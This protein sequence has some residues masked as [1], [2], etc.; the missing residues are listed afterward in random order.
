MSLLLLGGCEKEKPA[1]Q[2][3]AHVVV[4]VTND[5]G[6]PAVGERVKMYDEAT[7]ATFRKNNLTVPNDMKITDAKG[8][9]SFDFRSDVWFV[10]QSSRHPMFVVQ[11]GGGAD[12]FEI[13]ST[14]ETLK[15]GKT[16]RLSLQ[17]K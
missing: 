1:A 17:L 9:V 8:V 15:P 3:D 10:A 13:W 7:Y 14:G 11:H 2:G 5:D 4:T 12:N 6:S 16:L